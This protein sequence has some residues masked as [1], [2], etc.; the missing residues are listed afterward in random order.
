MVIAVC[1]L[2]FG[3]LARAAAMIL[4][5]QLRGIGT[6]Q[7]GTML[8][9]APVPPRNIGTRLPGLGSADLVSVSYLHIDS[10]RVSAEISS[11]RAGIV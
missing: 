4:T 6:G 8:E 5:V 1:R 10:Y 11:W 9:F 2:V 3:G 7:I